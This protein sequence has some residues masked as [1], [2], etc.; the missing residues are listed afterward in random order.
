MRNKT[1]EV[2]RLAMNLSTHNDTSI[3]SQNEITGLAWTCPSTYVVCSSTGADVLDALSLNMTQMNDALGLLT[4]G[5]FIFCW[6][7]FILFERA[8]RPAYLKLVSLK[9]NK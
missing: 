4:G 2:K 8:T 7:G 3:R 9:Q 5:I 1:R 6:I